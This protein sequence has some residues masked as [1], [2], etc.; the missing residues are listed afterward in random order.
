[1]AMVMEMETRQVAE[2]LKETVSK[3]ILGLGVLV[4]GAVEVLPLDLV[5]AVEAIQAMELIGAQQM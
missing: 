1:M 3:F 2:G 4:V 5:A